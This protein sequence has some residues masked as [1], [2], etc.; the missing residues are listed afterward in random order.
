LCLLVKYLHKL[1]GEVN[2]EGHEDKDIV[3]QREGRA[4]TSSPH[5]YRL[6]DGEKQ[7]IRDTATFEAE[8]LMRE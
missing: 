5:I 3:S 2:T 7:W 8:L 4:F 6:E 1:D